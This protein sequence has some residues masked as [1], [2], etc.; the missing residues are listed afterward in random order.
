MKLHGGADV[1]IHIFLISA[2][3]GGKRL[4]SPKT[5]CVHCSILKY[6]QYRLIG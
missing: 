4:A 1:Q 5:L 2:L 6:E 3:A